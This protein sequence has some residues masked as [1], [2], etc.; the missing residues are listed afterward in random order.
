MRQGLLLLF[1]NIYVV[2]EVH[3]AFLHVDQLAKISKK[4]IDV[5]SVKQLGFT[6]VKVKNKFKTIHVAIGSVIGVPYK[7]L[8]SNI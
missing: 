5:I 4:P 7:T 6:P 2:P 8:I 3:F 1:G